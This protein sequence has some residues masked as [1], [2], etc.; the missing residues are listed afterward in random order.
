MAGSGQKRSLVEARV[1]VALDREGISE[2][3]LGVIILLF[4]WPLPLTSLDHSSSS[5]TAA[6]SLVRRK[7][8]FGI[9]LL[10]VVCKTILYAPFSLERRP[11]RRAAAD[12]SS[13][14]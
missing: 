2:V 5:P 12:T 8:L 4:S 6:I 7:L 9:C 11:V 10:S 14:Y 1:V 3:R 13:L